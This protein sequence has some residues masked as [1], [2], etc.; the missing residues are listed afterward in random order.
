MLKPSKMKKARIIIS[1]EYYDDVV[2]ILQDIGAMQ[3]E[4]PGAEAARIAQ[5]GAGGIAAQKEIQNEAQR[6]RGLEGSLYKTA[7]DS[8]VSFGSIKE[9]MK[10]AGSIKIDERVSSIRKETEKEAAEIK[11]HSSRIAMLEIIQDFKGDLQI[12]SSGSVKSFIIYGKDGKKFIE[13]LKG[14][15]DISIIS[16]KDAWIV[17]IT[18][19][20]EKEF[21]GSAEGYKLSMQLIPQMHGNVA[22]AL[23]KE[24]KAK[25]RCEE[26]M[27]SL[28]HELITIS[29]RWYSK[30]SAIREQFDIEMD[31]VEVA[32][33]IGVSKSVAII[34]GWIPER[35]MGSIEKGIA[36]ISDGH[37]VLEQISSEEQPPT[38]FDN[39]A[40]SRL[41]EFFIRFYSL[42]KSDE[43]DPTLMF[44]IA[45]PIFFGFMVGDFAYGLIMLLGALW[46][47]RRLKH[48]PKKSRLPKKIV[49]FVTMIISPS[50]LE[51]IAKA[52]MPGA[53]IAMIL[54]VAFNEYM[55]FQL[56]YTALFNVEANLPTLLL[57]AGWIGV[58]MVEFGFALG[59]INNMA[60]GNKKHAVAKIGWMLAAIG[61]VIFGLNVLHKAQLGTPFSLAS[62][63]MI[64]AGVIAVLYGEG[65]Q[66]M[67]ELPSIVSHILSYVRLVGILLTSVILAGIIDLIF[68]HGVTHSILLGIVGIFILI[69]GQIFNLIIA[70]FE[71]GIQGARLIYVEFFSKFYSGNGVQ[72]KPFKSRRSRTLSRFIIE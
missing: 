54:G 50:G 39:P 14:S 28:Q 48:P 10:E 6:F 68:L 63:G 69:V 19:A 71:S 25:A 36:K 38:Q 15:D 45:F 2:S 22:E 72:F 58:V 18:A 47:L 65:V 23:E 35:Q 37:Y 66:S 60:H 44:A 7:S 24:R 67:M 52:I 1:K 61:I 43:I 33:K 11:E 21:S 8:K 17:S 46:L 51:I 20:G 26:S 70:I 40:W 62:F 32:N 64:I 41:F 12:F 4:T 34:E 9:L 29:D 31:K 49:S 30:V 27:K 13:K 53:V 5:I 55:G 16:L 56:P 42:P 3:I 59:F 57:I